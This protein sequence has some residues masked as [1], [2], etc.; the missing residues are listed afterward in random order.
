L[1]TLAVGAW[2]KIFS[3]VLMTYLLRNVSG[4]ALLEKSMSTKPGFKDYAEITP[5]FISWFPRKPQ[6]DK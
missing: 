3:R 1:F 5:A 4:V 2:W 6:N